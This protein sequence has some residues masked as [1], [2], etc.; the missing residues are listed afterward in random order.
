VDVGHRFEELGGFGR[1]GRYG[2]ARGVIGR[3]DLIV[4]VALASP[5]G[6]IRFLDWLADVRACG[7]APVHVIANR[8]HGGAFHAGE[9]EQEVRRT[10]SPPSFAIVPEDKR[11]ATAAWDGSRVPRG[12]FRKAVAAL[13]REVVRVPVGRP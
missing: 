6:V 10:Y 9:L 3:A 7:P 4:G 2:R 5:V 11:V 12:P 13:A 8:L 1:A